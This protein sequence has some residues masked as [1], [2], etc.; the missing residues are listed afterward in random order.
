MT[1]KEQNEFIA[2]QGI[3]ILLN[4]CAYTQVEILLKCQTLE[5]RT[6]ESSIS[7]L[8][9]GERPVG[10][11]AMRSL[12]D[13]I[14]KILAKE[15]CLVFEEKTQ[16]FIKIAGCTS[17]PIVTNE[18]SIEVSVENLNTG[19]LIHEGRVD[20][21]QKV[22]M[23][24]KA[25]YE[26]IEFG[27]RLRNFTDYFSSKRE[28]AF[29]DPIRQKLSDGVNFK[30]YVLN[31]DGNFAQRYMT[32]RAMVQPKE[33][34]KLA[35]SPRIIKELATACR[36]INKEGYIGKLS[37]FQYDHFPYFHA[38]VIDGDTGNGMMYLSSYLYG[39]SRANTPVVEIH[40]KQ[41][42]KIF[43]RYWDSIQAM[44]TS[45]TTIQLV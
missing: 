6:S 25:Q 13:G 29:L 23:Y 42:K 32:D 41:Q 5:I 21:P 31:P 1:L 4:E 35:D 7:N 2:R 36:Q 18:V 34:E 14:A 43:K 30:C 38:S 16:S 8:A 11:R 17:R 27:L 22:V 28:S 45:Q 19:Y 40:Q 10:S 44:T 3:K 12:A 33:K 24:Q 9:S 20:V 39:V 37:L 26:I 15:Q